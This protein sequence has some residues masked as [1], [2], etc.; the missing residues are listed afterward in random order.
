MMMTGIDSQSY[1]SSYIDDDDGFG[2]LNGVPVLSCDPL[3]GYVGN[4][5]DCDDQYRYQPRRH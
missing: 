1:V 2:N 5:T 4:N 3:S